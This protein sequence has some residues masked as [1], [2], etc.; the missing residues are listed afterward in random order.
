MSAMRVFVEFLVEACTNMNTTHT[1]H[2]SHSFVARDTPAFKHLSLATQ[3]WGLGQKCILLWDTCTR[4]CAISG[5]S[6]D[7]HVDCR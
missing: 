4:L 5:A 6:T 3:S 1:S 7:M 2:V